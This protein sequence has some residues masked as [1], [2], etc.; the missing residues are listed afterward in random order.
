MAVWWGLSD[1]GDVLV[2][3]VSRVGREG[4]ALVACGAEH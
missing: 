1:P 3:S 2:K 4:D